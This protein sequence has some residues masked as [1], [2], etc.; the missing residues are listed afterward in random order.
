[1]TYEVWIKDND[2]NDCWLIGNLSRGQAQDLLENLEGIFP[3]NRAWMEE[4]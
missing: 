4:W 3:D 2:G 1:M